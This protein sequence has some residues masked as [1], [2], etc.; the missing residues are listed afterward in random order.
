MLAFGALYLATAHAGA[1]VTFRPF[2]LPAF[3]PPA[4]LFVAVL[5]SSRT[6]EWPVLALAGATANVLFSSLQARTPWVAL[7]LAAR[8]TV[9]ALAGA[10]L[11]RRFVARRPKMGT[12]REVVGLASLSA[13][14]AT[15]FS[16]AAG[17]ALIAAVHGVR[18]VWDTW[19][20]WWIGD[21]V[22]ILTVAPIFLA[23][24]NGE[25]GPSWSARRWLEAA[26][27][28]ACLLSSAW[29]VFAWKPP[30][31]I[32]PLSH[33]YLLF[34]VLV[35]A[36]LRF[37]TSGA[38]GSM[39]VLSFIAFASA[40]RQLG[41]MSP[42]SIPPERL[43]LHLEAFLAV[44]TASTLLLAAVVQERAH[45]GRDLRLTQLAVDRA[46]DPIL[47]FDPSGAIRYANDATFRLLGLE[48]RDVIGRQLCE[49]DLSSSA[50]QWSA[51]WEEVK[52][53]GSILVE[54]TVKAR[55][56]GQVT[57]EASANY[58]AFRGQ[59]YLVVSLR[60]LADRR[61]AEEALRLTGMGTLAAGVAHEINNPL[62]FVMGNLTFVRELLGK[63]RPGKAD[64]AGP[65]EINEAIVAIDEALEGSSR[66]RE[67][68]R[69]LKAFSRA[70]GARRQPLDVREPL[71]RA[72][73]V[74]QNQIRH[75]ARLVTELGQVPPVLA[76]PGR[77]QQVFFNLLVNA[78]QAIPEG[79]V[80][81]NRIRVSTRAVHGRAV[82]EIA[83]TGCGMSPQVKSRI[84]DP[85]FTTKPVGTGTGLG[86]ST[87]HGIVT[88]LGGEI[89]VES[90][91]G[92]GTLVRVLLP[93]TGSAWPEGLAPPLPVRL[94]AARRR[95]LVV[96]DEPMVASAVQR[97]LSGHEVSGVTDPRHALARIQAGER[98]DAIL[99]DLMM[100]SMSGMEFQARLQQTAPSLAARLVFMTGGAFTSRAAEF[101]ER[102]RQPYLEKPF[103][104]DRL[105][106]ILARALARS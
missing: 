44:V 6:R 56:G 100:P 76:D 91:E 37:G 101:L 35:W 84:F 66:V 20:L 49:V 4:G 13:L 97:L 26:C 92:A 52:Q 42:S 50:E 60:D 105:R 2:P 3:W 67:I 81:Q 53:R 18:S 10:Y 8:N 47:F 54:T 106:E 94:D 28:L 85:F 11:V 39:L 57:L 79:R 63:L 1:A 5:L 61:R 12:V 95:I 68:V 72:I 78:A 80:D 41:E 71:Q 33:Q 30:S 87:C 51:R 82:V 99:C 102:S 65:A 69:D 48:S 70:D 75:R 89:Q 22:G 93:A 24:A 40:A 64:A 32:G 43:A 46:A 98:W 83:D 73:Q 14:A 31:G 15:L 96:D 25:K 21:A 19:A 58:L 38:S 36:A 104:R 74:A 55:E 17:T 86:L 45:A 59:E 27:L 16:A 103:D 90:D 9:E 62:S 7:V 77:L 34:P 29:V 23:W 88:G